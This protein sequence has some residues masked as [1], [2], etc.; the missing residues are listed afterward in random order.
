MLFLRYMY[1]FLSFNCKIWQ[2]FV[3]GDPYFTFMLCQIHK[4]SQS[5]SHQ[6]PR[7]ALIMTLFEYWF[8]LHKRQT[9]HW[10]ANECLAHITC[11]FAYVQQIDSKISGM[12]YIRSSWKATRQWKVFDRCWAMRASYSRLPFGKTE[13]A[14]VV[15]QKAE[16]NKNIARET[17]GLGSL[18]LPMSS[19]LDCLKN[20]I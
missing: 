19:F 3:S 12:S 16:K 18:F 9:N 1:S 20:P 5:I 7:H 2:S 15:G 10:T 11:T 14:S 4:H 13:S 6:I 8:T 17:Y